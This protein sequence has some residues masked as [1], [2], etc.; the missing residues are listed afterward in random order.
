MW[1]HVRT[2]VFRNGEGEDWVR[3]RCTLAKSW[4][5]PVVTVLSGTRLVENFDLSKVTSAL[6][7]LYLRKGKAD[8]DEMF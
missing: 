8:A 7:F 2:G 1:V 3:L 6:L 5:T 4:L